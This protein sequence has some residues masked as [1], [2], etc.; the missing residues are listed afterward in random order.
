MGLDLN[1]N[2]PGN[3]HAANQQTGAGPYPFSEPE[4]RSIGEFFVSHPNIAMALSY[5]TSGGWIL[6]ARTA[7]PDKDI[8]K[9]DLMSTSRSTQGYRDKGYPCVLSL[10]GSR[11][12]KA[13]VQ[14]EFPRLRV[15]H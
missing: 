8:R 5:H 6:R 1:R 7:G 12:T 15:R 14:R 2:Y 9:P 13:P 4:T 11:W 10:K 3:W